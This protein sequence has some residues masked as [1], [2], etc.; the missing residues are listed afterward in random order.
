MGIIDFNP[1]PASAGR[2]FFFCKKEK[3]QKFQS[4][5]R[6]RGATCCPLTNVKT[7]IGFQSTPRKRG[8]TSQL[9]DV[10]TQL[11]FQSTPR[12]R[13]ATLEN[14]IETAKSEIFQSTPRKRGAT[15][16]QSTD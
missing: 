4:T 7:T 10:N 13:G 9:E 15:Y 16:I 5:P 11:S 14:Q 2:L 8:A 6:K 12:K 3:N 1:R